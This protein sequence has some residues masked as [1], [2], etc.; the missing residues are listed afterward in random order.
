V[1]VPQAKGLLMI[2]PPLL[3]KMGPGNNPDV[4]HA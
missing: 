3:E 2:A 4:T 1:A